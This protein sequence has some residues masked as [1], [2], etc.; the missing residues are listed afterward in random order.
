MSEVLPEAWA[1]WVAGNLIRGRPQGELIEALVAEGHPAELARLEVA[2]LEASAGVVAARLALRPTVLALRLRR[3]HL[4][5]GSP[6]VP[7]RPGLD[8]ARLY[9]EH[10]AL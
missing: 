2:R 4:R 3:E 1:V 9:D 6:C 5:L 8:P 7:V 10:I